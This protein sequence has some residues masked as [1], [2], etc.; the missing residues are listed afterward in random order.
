MDLW[1]RLANGAARAVERAAT[2]AQSK[3][4]QVAKQISQAVQEADGLVP[5]PDSGPYRPDRNRYEAWLREILQDDILRFMPQVEP[6]SLPVDIR[7]YRET[8]G[9]TPDESLPAVGFRLPQRGDVIKRPVRDPLYQFF[10][11]HYGLYISDDC[12]FHY[13]SPESDTS[14]EA[15]RIVVTDLAG[16][17]AGYGVVIEAY[18]DLP[19][20]TPEA[21]EAAARAL[22]GLGGYD[23]AARNCEHF[24]TWCRYG[25]AFSSQTRREG[26]VF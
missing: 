5:P 7:Q 13:H 10:A 2:A 12:V 11:T 19:A 15:N 20:G 3:A 22:L 21:I 14:A 8:M 1:Q 24:A 17:A 4:E 9:H 25:R 26:S 6:G 23:L 18:S 16:F